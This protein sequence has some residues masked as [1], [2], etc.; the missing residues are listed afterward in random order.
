[1]L[2]PPP[3]IA[4]VVW[5]PVRTSDAA[6][7]AELHNEAY[8]VD[9]G[10]RITP[11]EVLNEMDIPALDFD[12]DT[13]VADLGGGALGA[14]ALCIVEDRGTPERQVQLG[15]NRVAPSLRGKGVGSF[16]IE[17]SEARGRQRVG[18]N[19][20]GSW[21][22]ASV[23]NWQQERLD[24]FERFAYERR[25]YFSEMLRDLSEPI[26]SGEIDSSFDVVGWTDELAE[27]A[28]SVH[29]EAFRDHWGSQP[30]G[31][32]HWA[33]FLDEF[34]L[35]EASF[36]AHRDGVPVGILLSAQYPHDFEDR[37]RTESWIEVVAVVPSARGHGLATGL[38][39]RAM[40]CFADAEVE[41]ACL[42]VDSESPT[43]ADRLYANLGF[44]VEKRSVTLG[45]SLQ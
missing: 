2:P 30:L 36:V 45:K 6:A 41:Y 15:W 29:N 10:Y 22:R 1:M 23:Y 17:W 27:D 14:V 8:A 11:Q 19:M 44:D 5:R 24:L 20:A 37:G 26:S 40:Q 18:S 12:E 28:R 39:T 21:F 43:G 42:T 4:G 7:V 32:Q 3:E 31:S 9:G 16:L 35:K 34:F 25:R 13:L 33:S 38:I